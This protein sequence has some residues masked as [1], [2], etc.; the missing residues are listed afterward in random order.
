MIIVSE[1]LL[2]AKIFTFTLHFRKKKLKIP[3]L[4]LV[5]TKEIKICLVLV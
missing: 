3:S 4:V 5:E 1:P 2:A